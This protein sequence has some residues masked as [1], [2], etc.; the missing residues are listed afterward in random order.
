MKSK[1]FYGE[2]TLKHWIDLLLS[3][4]I[5]LPEYQRRFQ[6]DM[7]DVMRLMK[8]LSEG[9]FVQPITI[10][11]YKPEGSLVSTN[12]LLDGQQRLSSVL[13]AYIG[14]FPDKDKFEYCED[15][16]TDDDG[17]EDE[18]SPVPDK[19][20][21]KWRFP[22]LLADDPSQNTISAITERIKTDG[23]YVE[24]KIDNLKDDFFETTYLGFSYIVPETSNKSEIDG[25]F[26]RLFRNI[27]Y[28]GK[29]LSVL[30]SRRS[31]YFLDERYK[32][33][34]DGTSSKGDVLGGIKI[35]E[36]YKPNTIDLVRY[37]S[38][39]SQYHPHSD[40][41]S[42]MK[43][44]SAYASRESYYSDFVSYI[45]GLDQE[46]F[47]EKFDEFKMQEVFPNDEWFERYNVLYD[48]IARLR[49][50]MDLTGNNAFKSW[51]DAD[52]WLFGL[53]FHI[54][55]KGMILK[56]DTADLKDQIELAIKDAHD[57]YGKSPNRLGNLRT[58]L[59][60]S[61]NIFSA[62]VQVNP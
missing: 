25:G 49:N 33:F 50:S 42:V 18:D 35:L 21:I 27:N 17:T 32:M 11:H 9:Q 6:W 62:Y 41:H 53:I 60:K 30:E 37:L 44:Y 45:I 54:V 10:A 2:Y 38:A 28:Y 13:L 34:F 52:F 46:W 22:N 24:M 47:S 20:P 7:P 3:K 59:E 51:I 15:Y 19:T 56:D 61:I 36:N 55:F 12:L 23:R 16:A 57:E 43:W 40:I 1:T 39:L 8:S 5:T 4:N 26:A 31:L 48:A 58:R 14:F 29:R